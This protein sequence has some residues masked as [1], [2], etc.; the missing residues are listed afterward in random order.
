MPGAPIDSVGRASSGWDIPSAERGGR[1]ESDLET[2][3]SLR[4]EGVARVVMVEFSY[5]A[6]PGNFD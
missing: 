4:V 3:R 6:R 5:R 2:V 1:M